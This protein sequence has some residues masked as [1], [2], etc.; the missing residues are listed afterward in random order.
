MATVAA[1][2]RYF[3]ELSRSASGSQHEYAGSRKVKQRFQY[4]MKSKS[5]FAE[6]KVGLRPTKEEFKAMLERV[7][8]V[9]EVRWQTSKQDQGNPGNH[10]FDTNLLVRGQTG[11]AYIEFELTRNQHST[12]LHMPFTVTAM[13]KDP[14]N[15]YV[16]EAWRILLAVTKDKQLYPQ[17]VQQYFM[18]HTARWADGEPNSDSDSDAPGKPDSEAD[19]KASAAASIRPLEKTR[20]SPFERPS[21]KAAEVAPEP[22]SNNAS[23]SSSPPPLGDTD[24]RPSS[25][26]QPSGLP[27]REPPRLHHDNDGDDPTPTEPQ[28]S[29]TQIRDAIA[30][31]SEPEFVPDWSAGDA[32]DE[33]GFTPTPRLSEEL[34][35]PLGRDIVDDM[36]HGTEQRQ[37]RQW[38]VPDFLNLSQE[39]VQDDGDALAEMQ[40]LKEAELEHVRWRRMPY[41]ETEPEVVANILAMRHQARASL[42]EESDLQ[43]LIGSTPEDQHEFLKAANKRSLAVNHLKDSPEDTPEILSEK[44]TKREEYRVLLQSLPDIT[45]SKW[46]PAKL[47][48]TEAKAHAMSKLVTK[49]SGKL[50]QLQWDWRLVRAAPGSASASRP[51]QWDCG[52]NRAKAGRADVEYGW[53]RCHVR[54][55]DE[56]I[57]SEWRKQDLRPNWAKQDS[58][59][60]CPCVEPSFGWV[61]VRCGKVTTLGELLMSLGK[62]WHAAQI[63]GFYRTLPL[64]AVKRRQGHGMMASSRSGATG[65]THNPLQACRMRLEQMPRKDQLLAEYAAVNNLGSLEPSKK[66]IDAAIRFMHRII[67]RDL[68]PP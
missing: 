55:V 44:K 21:I 67:L 59:I 16:G 23:A 2:K 33:T 22:S 35:Q 46:T 50:A 8:G 52:P 38:V 9:Q 41:D 56:Q 14:P 53:H 6:L 31:V 63:Y 19:P 48:T 51:E 64:V 62:Q 27:L 11:D 28:F 24:A 7:P 17:Q 1:K 4:S 20:L 66:N 30:L 43:L 29:H 5:A 60:T 26:S 34:Q 68:S 13:F 65:L 36:V 10:Y 54:K 37:M 3:E 32:V 57:W 18:E 49:R 45:V 40:R 25:A 47:E 61:W 12:G 39:C 58:R 42:V 15:G